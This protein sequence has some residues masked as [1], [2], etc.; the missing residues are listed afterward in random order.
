MEWVW[1]PI[2]LGVAP[3]VIW[4]LFHR[5]PRT[6]T[7]APSPD[8]APSAFQSEDIRDSFSSDYRASMLHDIQE[9]LAESIVSRSAATERWEVASNGSARST[10]SS[11]HSL[12]LGSHIGGHGYEYDFTRNRSAYNS[13]FFS[14]DRDSERLMWKAAA[15]KGVA[16][17]GLRI[18][19]VYSPLLAP[20]DSDEN[21][22]I[23]KKDDGFGDE[24]ATQATPNNSP[25]PATPSSAPRESSFSNMFRGSS[26]L[27]YYLRESERERRLDLGSIPPFNAVGRD[28]SDVGRMSTAARRRSQSSPLVPNNSVTRKSNVNI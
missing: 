21:G 7:R 2:W 1:V 22:D 16:P 24:E 18:P 10:V 28:E 9:R 17:V 15:M 8:P 5:L 4:T 27:V 13:H 20:D 12:G 11:S 3:L 6:K 23:M 25:H 14:K 26:P 19:A